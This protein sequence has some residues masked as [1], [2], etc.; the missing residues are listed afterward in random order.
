MAWTYLV[1]AGIFEWGWPVG[2]KL[3]WTDEG[4]HWG[5]IAFAIATMAASGALLL[6]AQRTIPMGTAYGV[7]TGIGAVGAFL[8]GILFFGEAATLARFFFIGLIVAG[9]LGL[10][11]SSGH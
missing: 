7:W 9:I 11:L 3:G 2:L 10:K 8:I 5:W 1:F 4:A 6:L